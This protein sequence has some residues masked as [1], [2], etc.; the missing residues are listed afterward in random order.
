[1]LTSLNSIMDVS[2]AETGT[3]CL[4]LETVNLATLIREMVELYQYV[5]E[6][7]DILVSIDCD[8]DIHITA[9]RNRMRRVVANLLDNAIKYTLPGIRV[10][11]HQTIM[12]F[13]NT[14]IG[15]PAEEVPDIWDRLYRGDKSQVTAWARSWFE[16]GKAIVAPIQDTLR[17]KA[18]RV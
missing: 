8:E 7:N 17:F 12:S 9:D 18:I 15:I 10:E 5:A 13:R 1:M 16:P 6:D 2:E 11:G 14:G 4:K 3:M